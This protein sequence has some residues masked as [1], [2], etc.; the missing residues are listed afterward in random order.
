MPMS[1]TLN[2]SFIRRPKRVFLCVTPDKLP[3]N[4]TINCISMYET[5][6]EVFTLLRVFAV[7]SFTRPRINELK[8]NIKTYH[9]CSWA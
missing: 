6:I 9:S 5:G 4:E 3:R 8:R 1:Q 7:I 2:R